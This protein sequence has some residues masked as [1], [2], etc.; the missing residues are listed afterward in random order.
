MR[1]TT[2]DLAKEEMKFSAGHFTIFGPGERENLHGHNFTIGV[3]LEG[4]IDEASGMLPD[5]RKYKELL[6]KQCRIWNES[7]LLPTR[8]PYLQIDTAPN[9]DVTAQ[10]G[11]ERLQFLARDVTLLPAANITVEELARVFGE[12][13]LAHADRLMSDGIC[14][15]RVRCGSGPGQ[16]ACWDWHK[17][18]IQ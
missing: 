17:A 15:I 6:I 13:L 8:S 2:I 12:S 10:F 3:E 1:T 9:G 4:Q 11:S 7:V 14:R 5:Y 16:T 18:P